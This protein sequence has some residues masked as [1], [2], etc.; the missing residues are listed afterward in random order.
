MIDGV[1]QLDALIKTLKI[2]EFNIANKY[3]KLN[4]KLN[5]LKVQ[6]KISTVEYN[7]L[8]KNLN[9][10][11]KNLEDLKKVSKKEQEYLDTLKAQSETSGIELVSD[12]YKY[13]TFS[14]IALILTI[15]ILVSIK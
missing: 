6:D 5:S 11:I 2:A 7:K 14:L 15:L 1:K 13:L 10:N 3:K 9:E 12:N 4:D 8:S